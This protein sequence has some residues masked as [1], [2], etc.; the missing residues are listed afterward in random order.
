ME[1]YETLQLPRRQQ[2]REEEGHDRREE[3]DYEPDASDPG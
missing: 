3:F 2:G 1:S